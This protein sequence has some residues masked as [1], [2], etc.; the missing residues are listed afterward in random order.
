VTIEQLPDFQDYTVVL[1]GLDGERLK[2]KITF[3]D[4]EYKD[5][6]VDVWET[7]Q[8]EH[9]KDPNACYTVRASDIASVERTAT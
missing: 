8:P 5:I 2:A 6:I 9:Y 1:C 4:L 7:N 3:V